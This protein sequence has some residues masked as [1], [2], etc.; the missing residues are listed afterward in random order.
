MRAIHKD[1]VPLTLGHRALDILIVLV[2][3]AGEVVSHR[4]LNSRVWRDLVVNPSNL[5]VHMTGLRKAL[6]DGEGD[7]RYIANVAGQGY[8]FVGP[9]N[10]E[11]GP[12]LVRAPDYP[13]GTARQRLVLPPVL[14]R[15]VGRE[16]VIRRIAADLIADRF[17]T[18]IGPG[19]MGKTTVAVSVAHAMRE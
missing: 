9:I 12:P 18:I 16:A 4:E 5:R 17:V 11:A 1:G 15:M 2:E 3:R 7:T 8:C 19:G 6:G 14:A 10:R 13:C